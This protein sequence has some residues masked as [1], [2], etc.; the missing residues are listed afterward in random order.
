MMRLALANRELH[1][2][3]QTWTRQTTRQGEGC[4]PGVHFLASLAHT[5]AARFT[6]HEKQHCCM[7]HA[8]L[9]LEGQRHLAFKI[10]RGKDSNNLETKL[11]YPFLQL[12][13]YKDISLQ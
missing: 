1:F 6:C 7:Q 4:V 8:M 13:A 11:S 3:K 5:N 2:F 9:Q 10:A 12:L